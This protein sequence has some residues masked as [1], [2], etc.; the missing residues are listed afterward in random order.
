[1]REF[2]SFEYNK[3]AS[4]KPLPLERNETTFLLPSSSKNT[5]D[6]RCGT[7]DKASKLYAFN[8]FIMSTNQ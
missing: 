1:M 4:V 2:H 5:V 6:F 3:V 7:M 8:Q